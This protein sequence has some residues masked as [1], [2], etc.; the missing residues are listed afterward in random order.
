MNAM[1]DDGDFFGV[2]VPA[3]LV[4]V[5]EAKLSKKSHGAVVRHRIDWGAH[6]ERL[7]LVGVFKQRLSYTGF[8]RLLSFVEADLAVGP[9]QS[10]RRAQGQPLVSPAG[11]L[12]TCISWLATTTFELLRALVELDSIGFS[13]ALKFFSTNTEMELE[14][15][16]S[17]LL[18]IMVCIGAIDGGYVRYASLAVMNAVVWSTCSLSKMLSDKRGPYFV[19]ADNAYPQ[20]Q[21]VLTPFKHDQL[22]TR[23]DRDSYN[24]C[25]S[26]C[27]ICIEMAFGL[28]VNKW[29]ILKR[30]LC[31]RLRNVLHVIHIYMRLHNFCI[32]QYTL[33][34]PI[35][36]RKVLRSM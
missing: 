15:Q 5:P 35:P 31:V 23:P 6:A 21:V 1:N 25:L 4:V 28:I 10:A 32:D 8:E 7:L 33:E 29:R 34:L 20:S 22:K 2:I 26:Q 36:P 24:F 3:V 13:L 12:Q 14:Q 18:V 11:M 19:V 17:D 16:D 9:V 27:R 30:P